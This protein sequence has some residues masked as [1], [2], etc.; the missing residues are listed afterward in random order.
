MGRLDLG[1]RVKITACNGL[2]GLPHPSSRAACVSVRFWPL[3][4]GRSVHLGLRR[5]GQALSHQPGVGDWTW[6]D[7]ECSIME[8]FGCTVVT[9]ITLG[10]THLCGNYHQ[11][12]EIVA[13]PGHCCFSISMVQTTAGNL[14]VPAAQKFRSEGDQEDGL[15]HGV[16][17][18]MITQIM[19]ANGSWYTPR[20]ASARRAAAIACVFRMLRKSIMEFHPRVPPSITCPLR[21]ASRI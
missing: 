16:M 21:F 4:A 2:R 14:P 13:I 17:V 3:Q 11:V 8:H 1:L 9:R 20:P 18:H 6:P 5:R 19:S 10:V 12:N 7:A 15:S